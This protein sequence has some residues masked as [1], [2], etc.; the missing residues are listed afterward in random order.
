MSEAVKLIVGGYV[1]LKNREAL[2]EMRDHRQRLRERLPDP[3]KTLNGVMNAADILT[4]DILAID[5]GLEEL[6][7]PG[8]ETDPN[9]SN[10][11]D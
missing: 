4:A 7:G 5:E 6:S 2:E 9:G 1:R 11:P 3:Q 10:G 8:A